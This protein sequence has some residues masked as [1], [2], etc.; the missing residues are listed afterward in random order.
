MNVT[1]EALHSDS[2]KLGSFEY[3]GDSTIL[4]LN[5]LLLFTFLKV[6]PDLLC[7]FECLVSIDIQALVACFMPKDPR[8]EHRTSGT[9][10]ADDSEPPSTY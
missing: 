6:F 9:G 10:D 8:R 1:E 3:H 4:A 5:E 7:V 2:I